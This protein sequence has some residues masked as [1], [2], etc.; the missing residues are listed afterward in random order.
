MPTD[1]PV[2]E[3]LYSAAEERTMNKM[4]EYSVLIMELRSEITDIGV[5][6]EERSGYLQVVK[7]IPPPRLCEDMTYAQLKSANIAN[8]RYLQAVINE[9]RYL[10]HERRY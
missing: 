8:H 10:W 5:R 1:T 2:Y 6:L 7:H 3:S 9:Y 4:N